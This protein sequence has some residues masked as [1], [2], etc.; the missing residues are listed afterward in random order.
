LKRFGV[1]VVSM[2]QEFS[3]DPQGELIRKI[4][5]LFDEYSSAENA[6]HVLRAMLQNARNGFWNGSRPPF[7]Y[8]TVEA[9]RRGDKV[10]KVLVIDEAEAV[11][12]RLMFELY[13]RGDEVIGPMG[14]K[15][16][17]AYLNRKGMKHR[18]HRFHV[19]IV[20]KILTRTIYRGTHVFNKLSSKSGRAKPAE[21]WVLVPVP[22]IINEADFA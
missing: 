20:H 11:I 16:I 18:G 4:I 12:I 10:K 6:K 5:A 22:A 13:L 19:A 21:E 9:E 8:R 1:R 15:A 17:T 14:V 2:T 3:N 7:G